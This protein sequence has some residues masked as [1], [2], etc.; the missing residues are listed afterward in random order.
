MPSLPEQIGFIAHL[1]HTLKE[2]YDGV[3]NFKYFGEAKL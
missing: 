3:Y 2:E 1:F